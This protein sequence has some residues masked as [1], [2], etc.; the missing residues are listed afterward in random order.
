MRYGLGESEAERE[1]GVGKAIERVSIGVLDD[2]KGHR[3]G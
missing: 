1:D 2:R 3:R